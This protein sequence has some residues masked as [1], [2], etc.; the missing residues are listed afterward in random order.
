MQAEYGAHYLVIYSDITA[1]RELYSY[2]TKIQLEDK[3]EIVM[4]IHYLETDDTIRQT[5]TEN[6]ANINIQKYES[7]DEGNSSLI[8][9]DSTKAYF[10]LGDV[11]KMELEKYIQNL[12]KRAQKQGKNGVSVVTDVGAFYLY[13]EMQKLVEYEQSLPIR[14]DTKLKRFCFCSQNY[15]DK[16]TEEQKQ[17]LLSCHVKCLLA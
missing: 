12:L 13:E 3:N 1:L 7:K 9:M 17:K 4:L 2:Y 10:G 5:L 11:D 15:F 8:I 16:L 6:A 14:Y